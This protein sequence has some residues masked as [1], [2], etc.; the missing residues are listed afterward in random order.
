MNRS[1]LERTLPTCNRARADPSTPCDPEAS[2]LTGAAN[3]IEASSAVESAWPRTGGMPKEM[4]GLTKGK[5]LQQKERLRSF[6]VK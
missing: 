3:R 6:A 2:E 1:K 5:V 4:K